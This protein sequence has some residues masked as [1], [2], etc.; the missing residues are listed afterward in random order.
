MPKRVRITARW[1]VWR[2]S[3]AREAP[4]ARR[5]AVAKTTEIPTTKTKVGQTRSVGVRPFHMAWFM[6]RHEPGPPLLFTMIMK[7]IVTPR[8][9]SSESRRCVGLA[10]V[11]EPDVGVEARAGA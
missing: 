1:I 2:A 9:T 8:A 6:K 10:T 3:C 7:A 11:A 4:R 5:A